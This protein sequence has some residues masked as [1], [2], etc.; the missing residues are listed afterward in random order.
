VRGAE[1][2]PTAADFTNEDI[3]NIAKIQAVHR[4][5]RARKEVQDIRAALEQPGPVT[6]PVDL[7]KFDKRD[8]QDITKIQSLQRGRQGR[9]KAQAR[10]GQEG[11]ETSQDAELSR[12]G[13]E[14]GLGESLDGFEGD[15]GLLAAGGG[16]DDGTD[17]P[18]DNGAGEYQDLMNLLREYR[19]ALR[20]LFHRYVTIKDE[21]GND[22]IELT[23]FLR[24]LTDYEICPIVDPPGMLA[25]A[26][27][28]VPHGLT[29]QGASQVFGSVCFTYD[30]AVSFYEFVESMVRVATSVHLVERERD[31]FDKGN[32]TI[33]FTPSR[34]NRYS[35]TP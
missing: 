26:L 24:L 18:A 17:T 34:S 10:R 30:H 16:P 33:T 28:A 13:H 25:N 14:G 3:Q 1:G 7:S 29:R 19:E 15:L 12:F 22:M 11:Q 6:A 20:A 35:V 27:P 8:V 5:N 2:L 23:D 32:H 9:K 31:F 21:R 4:G